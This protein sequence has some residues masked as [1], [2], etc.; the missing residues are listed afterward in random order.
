MKTYLQRT[1]IAFMVCVLASITA[2]ADNVKKGSFTLTSE[3][4]VNGT[5][6]K[7]GDYDVKF[8]EQTNELAILKDGKVKVKTTGRLEARNEKAK[9]TT[10]RTRTQGNVDELIAVTFSGAMQ[11]VV[12]TSP[13]ASVN[14]SNQ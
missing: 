7:A 1:L 13:G 6:L 8:N 3:V 9:T 12:V 4:V 5:V 11:D 10:I 2:F 14:G